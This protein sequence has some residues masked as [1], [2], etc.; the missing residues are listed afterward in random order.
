MH[1]TDRPRVRISLPPIPLNIDA[2]A[3]YD[4]ADWLSVVGGA[5]RLEAVYSRSWGGAV[6]RVMVVDDNAMIRT[7]VR[8][9]LRQGGMEVVEVADGSAV[10]GEIRAAPVDLV[11]CDLFMPGFDGLEVLRELR[12]EFPSIKVIVM[13]GGSFKGTVDL[14]SVARRLGAVDIL[15]KP[16]RRQDVLAAV[17]RAFGP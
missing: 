14:L 16:F 2:S 1:V 15:E 13:S 12:R 7:M 4:G 5:G 3:C 9:M 17:E 6:T 10:I 8:A 11:I